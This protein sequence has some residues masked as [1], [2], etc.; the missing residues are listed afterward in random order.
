MRCEMG[1][2]CLLTET[3]WLYGAEM[4][5]Q[6]WALQHAGSRRLQAS[7]GARTCFVAVAI[8]HYGDLSHAGGEARRDHHLALVIIAVDLA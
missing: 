7:R 4:Q 3:G 5:C 8:C 1:A 2:L 6:I